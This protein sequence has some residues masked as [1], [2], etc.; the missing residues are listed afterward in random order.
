ML[1]NIE[2]KVLSLNDINNKLLD[3]FNRYQKVKKCYVNDNGKWI[4]KSNE[5]IENWDQDKKYNVI[6]YFS[7]AIDEGSF[8]IGAY[9][10]NNLIGFSVLLN[11][12]F[13]K[14]KNY[15]ELKYLHVSFG[16]RHK[17][18]GKKLFELCIKKAKNIGIEKIYI[19]TNS[20]EETQK[21]YLDIG[22]IDALEINKEAAENEPYDRQM[23]YI[24]K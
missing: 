19:S 5:F 20:A 21:F 2:F 15:V 23:E 10:N 9:D 17:G 3:D 18:I 11:K 16:Y 7:N 22:C 14:K 4:L 13:G 12:K 1:K 24:I 6:K 8:V